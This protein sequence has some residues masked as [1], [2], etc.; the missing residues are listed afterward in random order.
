MYTLKNL[1]VQV[2]SHDV[3]YFLSYGI[4]AQI[5]LGTEES[6]LDSRRL[7]LVEQLLEQVG[8]ERLV[9]TAEQLLSAAK[10]VC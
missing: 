9:L 3:V 2:V 5:V 8:V 1:E 10:K 6:A 7:T 4:G